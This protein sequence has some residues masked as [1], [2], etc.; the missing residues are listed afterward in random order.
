MIQM[1]ACYL[2]QMI[3]DCKY[4][5]M[6]VTKQPMMLTKLWHLIMNLL[7]QYFVMDSDHVD[8]HY[9]NFHHCLKKLHQI[10]TK[11]SLFKDS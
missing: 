1:L 9:P 3:I 7:L 2:P 4:L 8:I 10:N 5:I 6:K 11:K